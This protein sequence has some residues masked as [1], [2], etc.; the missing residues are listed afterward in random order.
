MNCNTHEVN[1]DDSHNHSHSQ[2]AEHQSNTHLSCNNGNG[3]GFVNQSACVRGL[4]DQLRQNFVGGMVML[5][6]GINAL[7]DADRLAVMNKVRSFNNFT[8]DNDPHGEHDFGSFKHNAETY[9][10][11][12]DCYDLQMLA[13]SP[14]P[15]DPSVTKR[16]LT[17][18]MAQ[19]Y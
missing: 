19:E 7:S 1:H 6:H 10:W 13:H 14:D 12:I 4:N 3:A 5:T 11:K 8:P 16:V 2:P 18:M 17:I 9:F 15:T